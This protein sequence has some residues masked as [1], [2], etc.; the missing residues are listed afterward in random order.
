MINIETKGLVGPTYKL[1]PTMQS[2]SVCIL[3]CSC[4]NAMI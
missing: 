4:E 2:Y 3:T 1:A